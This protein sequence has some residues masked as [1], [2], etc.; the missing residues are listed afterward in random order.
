MDRTFWHKTTHAKDVSVSI[1]TNQ[2]GN[3]PDGNRSR[4]SRRP[5]GGG[6]GLKQ[7]S[8]GS[9]IAADPR[10]GWFL[11]YHGPLH[12]DSPSAPSRA[13]DTADCSRR[14]GQADAIL[15]FF[16]KPRPP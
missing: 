13:N 1:A 12:H 7:R 8:R 10:G 14:K 16:E 15:F 9:K 5:K 2:T 11:D 6:G 3:R 4:P